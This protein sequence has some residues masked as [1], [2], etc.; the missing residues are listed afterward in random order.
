MGSWFY[1][2]ILLCSDGSYYVGHTD[3]LEYRLAEHERGDGAQYTR[4]RLPVQLK[5]HERFRTRDEAKAAESQVKRW[6]RAKKEALIEGRFDLISRLAG[7][8]K[9]ARALRDALLRPSAGSGLR[10]APQERGS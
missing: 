4:S 1:T 9:E 7:R 10:K 2:Y 3:R 6:N 8:S 5:W